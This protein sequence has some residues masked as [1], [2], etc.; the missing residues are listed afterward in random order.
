MNFKP[1]G[2]IQPDAPF[3]PAGQGQQMQQR[4]PQQQTPQPNQQQQQQQQGNQNQNQSPMNQKLKPILKQGPPTSGPGTVAPSTPT[5]GAPGAPTAV[6]QGT[7][8]NAQ[9]AQTPK[10]AIKTGP[11]VTP[12]GPG[13]VKGD[14]AAA[15]NAGA[16]A[17]ENAQGEESMDDTKWIEE[18]KNWMETEEGLAGQWLDTDEDGVQLPKW[19][20][21]KK[22]AA[23]KFFKFF[24]SGKIF[25][26]AYK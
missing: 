14:A 13:A 24:L 9:G 23:R 7:N 15:K 1:G 19:R 3:K 4:P 20:R 10:P 5:T 16:A 25:S 2:I 21:F 26:G 22:I 17:G 6:G 18:Q 8:P 11:P 12:G